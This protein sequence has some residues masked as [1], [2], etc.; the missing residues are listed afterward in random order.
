[1]IIANGLV[2]S[3]FVSIRLQYYIKSV[4]RQAPQ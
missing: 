3:C 2:F 1:M 4:I